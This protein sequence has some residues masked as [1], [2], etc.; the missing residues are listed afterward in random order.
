M[1]GQ[2]AARDTQ[3]ATLVTFVV[4]RADFVAYTTSGFQFSIPPEKYFLTI[5]LLISRIIRDINSVSK[6]SKPE[7][8]DVK[9]QYQVLL[10]RLPLS[11]V[12][13]RLGRINRSADSGKGR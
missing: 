11:T 12:S 5:I 9:E 2:R 3:L 7:L 8:E 13:K 1:Y 6:I 10:G 4:H